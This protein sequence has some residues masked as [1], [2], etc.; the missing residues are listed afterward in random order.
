MDSF[1]FLDLFHINCY[2]SFLLFKKRIINYTM[3]VKL[4]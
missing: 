4:F 3:F 1:Y 2:L